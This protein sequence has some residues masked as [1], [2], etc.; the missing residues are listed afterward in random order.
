MF[1]MVSHLYHLQNPSS[2]YALLA[3]GRNS[4][5]GS[6]K[7]PPGGLLTNDFS[8]QDGALMSPLSSPGAALHTA[9][10]GHYIRDFFQGPS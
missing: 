1:K 6:I 4:P 8:E 2:P 9:S 7:A 3:G 5:W 10:S